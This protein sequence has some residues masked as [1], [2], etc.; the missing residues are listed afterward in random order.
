MP[1]K[2][3]NPAT[4]ETFAQ[5]EELTDFQLEEKI[6]VAHAQYQTWRTRSFE[7]RARPM[8]ALANLLRERKRE[9]AEV[10]SLEMGKPIKQA[11][12]EV[13]KCAWVCEYYAQETAH[14]LAPEKV[15]TDAQLS[16]VRFDPIGV[17]LAV[18][19]WNFPYWQVFRFAA[20]AAMAG[21]VGVLKHASNVPQCAAKI[22]ELFDAAGFP[23]GVFQNLAIGS[24]RV[25]RVLRDARVVAATLTGSEYAG[26]QVA[27]ICGEEIKKTV[28]ELGGSDPFIVLADADLDAVAKA[29]SLARLQNAGQSCIAAKRF[30]LVRDIADR[31]IAGFK[32][33]FEA[34]RV[35]DPLD[36]QTDMGPMV[37][38]KS[39]LEV[40]RIVK[41]SVAR[42]ARLITG[43]ARLSRAGFFY[44]P[45]ILSNV[46]K[47]MPAYEEETVG[48]VISLL[49]V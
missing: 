37:D 38:E 26:T 10:A 44:A 45:T 29:G 43:G 28:L 19:P 30:I 42:G 12:G 22:E 41:E 11:L 18:M 21:N 33:K 23:K 31:V 5:F 14:I 46:Q 9:L 2:S 8:F 15:A 3:I 49:F 4:G 1:L 48:P 17:I 7:E 39:L 36:E 16:Y 25:E 40:D 35:G 32:E 24:S 34:M 27:R 47:G 13:E 6:A 20:P